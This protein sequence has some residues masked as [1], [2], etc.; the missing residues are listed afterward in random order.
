M[1]LRK[2]SYSCISTNKA[3]QGFCSPA[4]NSEQQWQRAKHMSNAEEA[5]PTKYLP[6][7]DSML[8]ETGI[9]SGELSPQKK[10]NKKN[11]NK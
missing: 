9:F 3:Y 10:K 5:H 4:I 7:L 8:Q 1:A 11:Q 6:T 2:Q